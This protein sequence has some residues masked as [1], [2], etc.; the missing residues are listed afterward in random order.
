[1]DLN[2]YE[3]PVNQMILVEEAFML[4]ELLKELQN[5][6]SVVWFPNIFRNSPQYCAFTVWSY[7]LCIR[8]IVFANWGIKIKLRNHS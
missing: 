2:R 1:M 4:L 3:N 7:G 6:V 5:E 8:M